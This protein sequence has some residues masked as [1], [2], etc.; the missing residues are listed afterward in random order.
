MFARDPV[1]PSTR[2][3][4]C[5]RRIDRGGRAFP[6]WRSPFGFID[7]MRDAPTRTPSVPPAVEPSASGDARE[8]C[9]M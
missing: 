1:A 4:Y 7:T 9:R 3:A 6:R 5:A 2:T 8:E